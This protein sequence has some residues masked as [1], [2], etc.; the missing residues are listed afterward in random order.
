M[1]SAAFH[2]RLPGEQ[3]RGSARGVSGDGGNVGR[4]LEIKGV[5]ALARAL[6]LLDSV[7]S[8]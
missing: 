7:C 6:S 3:E 8:C 1:P 2:G 4:C 5:R